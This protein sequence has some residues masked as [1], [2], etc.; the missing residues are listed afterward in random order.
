MNAPALLALDLL[1]L[2]PLGR[3]LEPRLVVVHLDTFHTSL[4][5]LPFLL[6][7]NNLAL[8]LRHGSDLLFTSGKLCEGLLW[9]RRGLE[10]YMVVLFT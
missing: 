3:L 1:L 4:G 2:L 7:C 9:V 8:F 6:L 5:L 10:M